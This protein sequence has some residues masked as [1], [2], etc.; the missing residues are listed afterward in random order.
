MS[1]VDMVS[2]GGSLAKRKTTMDM[3]HS[4]TDTVAGGFSVASQVVGSVV[5]LLCALVGAAYWIGNIGANQA[6]N[7]TSPVRPTSVQMPWG[8]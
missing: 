3:A 8:R 5:I 2:R 4:V 1:D 7:N 6:V